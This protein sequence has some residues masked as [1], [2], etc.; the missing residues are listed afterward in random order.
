MNARPQYRR[1][2]LALAALVPGVCL[3]QS[4]ALTPEQQKRVDDTVRQERERTDAARRQ[5]QDQLNAERQATELT[6]VEAE[7]AEARRNESRAGFQVT[8]SQ[9]VTD[10]GLNAYQQ[11]DHLQSRNAEENIQQI[12]AAI[13]KWQADRHTGSARGFN[14]LQIEN[15]FAGSAG[16]GSSPSCLALDSEWNAIKV[17]A[18]CG[19]EIC[20]G[21]L[22]KDDILLTPQGNP[23]TSWTDVR[24]FLGQCAVERGAAVLR[25]SIN[26]AVLVP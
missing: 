12:R 4:V 17:V 18:V 16:G 10:A 1:S 24:A 15:P 11:R 9:V 6:R 25:P 8:G 3:A 2:W 21:G 14:P 7:L 23:V 22:Q 26:D 19:P 13:G 20:K 5:L